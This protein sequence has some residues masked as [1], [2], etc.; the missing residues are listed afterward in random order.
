MSDNVVMKIISFEELV[1]EF[2]SE[3]SALLL[4]CFGG[5][6]RYADSILKR[7]YVLNEGVVGTLWRDGKLAAAYSVVFDAFGRN[8]ALSVDTM[9]NGQVRS[10]TVKLAPEVYDYLREKNIDILY[11]FP[12]E[13]IINLRVR[14]LGWL[15]LEE[16]FFYLT[17][18]RRKND[19]RAPDTA[20]ALKR[21][22]G[23]VF[24]NS[25]KG[26]ILR[27]LVMIGFRLQLSRVKPSIFAARV[28]CKYLCCKVLREGYDPIG[29]IDEYGIDVP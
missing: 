7:K 13:K 23:F 8:T 27:F 21:P 24:S 3:W 2:A 18:G 15:K 25:I 4:E 9:S 20:F 26:L 16:K 10:A 28:D 22:A 5:S 1:S 29:N 11:G 19:S 6:K 17:Y 14:K 12:N